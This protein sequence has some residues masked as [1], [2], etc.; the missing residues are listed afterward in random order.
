MYLDLSLMT[1]DMV[2][3]GLLRPIRKIMK[4]GTQ[5]NSDIFEILAY[6]SVP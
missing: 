3:E 4:S 2:L 6:S 1:P 5:R